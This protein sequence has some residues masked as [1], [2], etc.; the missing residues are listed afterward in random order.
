ML[1]GYL[2]AF[3]VYQNK[4]KIK[5]LPAM[6]ENWV[7]SSGH[8]DPLEKGMAMHTSILAYRIPKI[9]ELGRLPSMGSQR[10]GHD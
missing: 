3:R 8:E 1:D 10:V 7:Q 5:K 4:L 6:W 2:T 9:D